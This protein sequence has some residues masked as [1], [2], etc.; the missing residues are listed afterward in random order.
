MTYVIFLLFFSFALYLGNAAVSI[1][2]GILFALTIKPEK[3]FISRTIGTTPLQIGI[4]IL[5]ATISLPYAWS[6]SASYLPWISLFVISSFFTGLLLG[7]LLGIQRRIA[8]LLS[9][10]AAICGGTAMAA[11]APIIKVRPQE[12]MVGMTIVFLLNAIAIVVFPMMGDYLEM[13]NFQF[14]AWSA[15]AIHDTSSVI[16]SALTYSDESAQ[17]AATLK[18]GRTIWI[19]P[20]ILITNWVF[21]RETEATKFPRFILFFILA[22]TINTLFNFH[23]EVLEILKLLSQSFLMLGLFCIGTQFQAQEFKA[24]S[25]RP[26]ILAL[27]IW[28]MV[29]PASY[30]LV[31]YL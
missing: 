7:K 15:L 16:G 27:I 1:F 6:V 24:I 14:G 18:L 17:V 20:L 5:G 28:L 23:G 26:L 29:I 31:T 10:G 30:F 12:L 13:T 9:A 2:L 8:F 19:I 25:G 22:I 21:N 4:V 3:T 11:I